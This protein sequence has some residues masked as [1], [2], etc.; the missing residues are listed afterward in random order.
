MPNRILKESICTSPTIEQLTVEEE[1]FFYR[2]M[3]ACDDYG[4]FDAR[5]PILRA[6]CFPLKLDRVSDADVRRWLARLQEVGLLTLYAVK[7]QPY[8]QL[9]TWGSHQQIRAQRSK[10]PPPDIADED[11]AITCNQLISGASTCP[12]NP[13]QSESNPNPNP[14]ARARADSKPKPMLERTPSAQQEMVGALCR[15]DGSPV[16]GLP[17][18]EVKRIGKLAAACVKV[19][20]SVKAVEKIAELW[21]IEHPDI[22][23]TAA[24]VVKHGARLLAH[25]P[26][27]P[28]ISRNGR[29]NGVTILAPTNAEPGI[30]QAD[31]TI[32]D[33]QGNVIGRDKYARN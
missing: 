7:G 19:G 22:P 21:A 31:G 28:S 32:V 27:G 1:V 3:V 20:W 8:L 17:E 25:P 23:C 9:T 33:S 11:S 26:R 16:D 12:R 2:L 15:V 5:P 14:L 24:V 29:A 6:R 13:I 18:P 4:I 10:F 30:Y